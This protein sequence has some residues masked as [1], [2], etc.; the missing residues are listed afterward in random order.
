MSKNKMTSSMVAAARKTAMDDTQQHLLNLKLARL[1]AKLRMRQ[2]TGFDGQKADA[3]IIRQYE[4]DIVSWEGMYQDTKKSYK[5]Y[6]GSVTYRAEQKLNKVTGKVKSWFK[7]N[8]A[9]AQA[10]A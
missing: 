2:E 5:N 3:D 9:P 8:P 4:D 10:A 7:K 1:R 6:I